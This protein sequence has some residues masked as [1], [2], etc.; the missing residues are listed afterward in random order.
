MYY[1]DELIEEVRM[2]SDI[3]DVISGFRDAFLRHPSAM[4]GSGDIDLL[5]F[6]YGK[7]IRHSAYIITYDFL[8]RLSLIHQ[9]NVI[10]RQKFL[11]D[12]AGVN[13]PEAEYNEE[14]RKREGRRARLLEV[15]KEAAKYF[16]YQLRGESG[17]G[18]LK[19][20]M[21]RELYSLHIK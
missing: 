10:S 4:P 21:G 6:G 3:V 2:K 20:L 17:K 13:L 7:P 15:N 1:P 9:L 19:Y 18:G 5:I 12:R 14:T 16:F 8:L 11:A